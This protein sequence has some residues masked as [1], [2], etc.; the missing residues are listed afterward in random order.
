MDTA[1]SDRVAVVDDV[2]AI[3]VL[4]ERCHAESLRQSRNLVVGGSPAPRAANVNT[5]KRSRG[6]RIYVN[7]MFR[8]RL[9]SGLVGEWVCVM[10]LNFLQ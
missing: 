1:P 9:V 8:E 3:V 4:G 2:D 5:F 6:L 7:V 10:P